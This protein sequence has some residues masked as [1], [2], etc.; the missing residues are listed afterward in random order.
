MLFFDPTSPTLSAMD[1]AV[2]Q[3]ATS[4][5]QDLFSLMEE[6]ECGWWDLAFAQN[7]RAKPFLTAVRNLDGETLLHVAARKCYENE[8]LLLLVAG[9]DVNAVDK[10]GRTPLHLVA[11]LKRE[12]AWMIRDMLALKKANLDARTDNGDTPLMVAT[13]ANDQRTIEFLVWMGASLKAPAAD[14]ASLGDIA[15]DA[16]NVEAA[17]LLADSDDEPAITINAKN[18][19]IP[20]Y[21]ARAFTDAA[22][23][24]DYAL[25]SDLMIDGVDINTRDPD[26]A[27]ALHRAVYRAHED[28][29][30]FLLMLGANPDL[31]DKNGNTPYMAASSWFGLS[32]DWMRAMLL[33]SSGKTTEPIN[34]RGF[35]PLDAAVH[36]GNEESAQLLIWAGA[37][38]RIETGDQGTPMTIACRAGSQRLIDLLRRNGVTE[39]EFVDADPQLRLEQYV[40]RGLTPQA[41]ELV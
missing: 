9:A 27:T 30:T 37:D 5:N 15:L 8:V 38:S 13:K 26:G 10:H 19:R 2:P 36:A 11:G 39:P 25:L 31:T 4:S 35:S 40:K 16:G 34:Q 29:V 18:H 33:L 28:V 3:I 21:I 22:A 6:R 20:N 24:K 23:K 32:M 14:A 17:A 7:L 12:D 41:L 1:E